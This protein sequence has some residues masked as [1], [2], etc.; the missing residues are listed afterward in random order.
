[1]AGNAAKASQSE[2]SWTGTIRSVEAREH[3]LSVKG[4]FLRP[5]KRF[6]IGES[7]AVILPDQKS[8][9]IGDLRPGQKVLISYQD[10]AGVLVA[11]RVEQESVCFK[12][13]VLTLDP[14]AGR[15][16]V[17]CGT[18]DNSVAISP[19]CSVV[20]HN[21]KRGTLADIEPGQLVTVTF[22]NP[23]QGAVAREIAQTSQTYSGTLVAIDLTERVIKTKGTF[24]SKKFILADDC[25][26]VLLGKPDAGLR[27]LKLGDKLDFTFDEVN[28]VN[29]AN[30]IG[31]IAE[32]SG[33]TTAQATR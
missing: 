17:R 32:A 18:M 24:G 12:G 3:T 31:D 2:K 13:R 9:A 27:D 33:A 28:G 5:A 1:M 19:D 20:L 30:R 16:V 6:A 4:S 29:V 21:H 8:G 11:N 7:C 26:I 22:E 10:V 23:P 25:R 14:Q 15:L